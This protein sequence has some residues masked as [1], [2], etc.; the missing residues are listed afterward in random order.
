MTRRTIALPAVGGRL[1]RVPLGA[2]VA[3]VKR[4]KASPNVTF[5]HGLTTWWPTTGAE[6]VEQFRRGMFDRIDAAV[7]Y[8]RRP[9]ATFDESIR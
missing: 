7:P 5:K 6:I 8:I 4:A 2:Y 1:R 3:A 9:G